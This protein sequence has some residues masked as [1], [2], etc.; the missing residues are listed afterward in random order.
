MAN[1]NFNLVN[2]TAS[3]TV[4]AY[5]TGQALDNNNALFLLQ[6]DGKKPYYPTSPSSTCVPLAEDCAIPLGAS[7]S[8]TTVTIPHLASGRI[9]FSIDTPLK[10]MLNPGPGLV[11]PSVANPSDPNAAIQ[12]GFC[13]FTWNSAQLFVNISYVDFVS[14]PIG[15]AL[16]NTADATQIVTGMPANG[17]DT[18]CAGLNAQQAIDNTGWA[19]LIE[20]SH[21]GSNLRALSPNTGIARNSALFQG[22]YDSQVDQV[23][24]KYSAPSKAMTTDTQASWARVPGHC[25]AQTGLL[26]FGPELTFSKPS[27]A[28]VFGCSTGPFA[29]TSN[30][31]RGALIARL[32]A[33]LNRTTLLVDE[34]TPCASPEKYYRERVTNHYARIVHAAN[35]DDK[36]YAFPFDD[37]TPTGGVDQSGAVQD[38]NPGLLT[39]NVGGRGV[40]ASRM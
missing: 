24:A 29:P 23:W 32:C 40:S 12:W 1:L 30:V 28:D 2:Q 19:S 8:T 34:V 15:L 4:Y 20:T 27:T 38:G 13:E 10:F 25:D 39:V 9:W 7:G 36:G 31:Q 11:E 33:G 3:N 6:A 37:V 22:Y 14:L 18:I 21:D 5:V 35:A 16:T 26:S 17:L